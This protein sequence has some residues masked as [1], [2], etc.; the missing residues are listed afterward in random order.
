MGRE[1]HE[2]VVG[3][4]MVKTGGDTVVSTRLL[5]HVGLDEVAAEAH[6]EILVELGIGCEAGVVALHVGAVDDTARVS[7]AEGED[8]VRRTGIVGYA[9][10]VAEGVASLEEALDVVIDSGGGPRIEAGFGTLRLII[11][12]GMDALGIGVAV[13]DISAITGIVGEL[14]YERTP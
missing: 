8:E 11:H 1:S 14:G 5:V 6:G 7:V 10:I 2:V 13:G 9:D 3:G 12:S 4:N